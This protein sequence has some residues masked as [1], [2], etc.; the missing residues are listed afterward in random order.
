MA[1]RIKRRRRKRIVTGKNVPTKSHTR[2]ARGPKPG[3][4]VK[5]RSYKRRPPRS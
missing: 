4:R 1:P 3:P 2:D 5:V